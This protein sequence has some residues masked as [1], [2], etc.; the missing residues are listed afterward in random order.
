MRRPCGHVQSVQK[1]LAGSWTQESGNAVE[2]RRLAGTVR[3]DQRV[4][5]AVPHLEVDPVHRAQRAKI[6]RQIA[7]YK[8]GCHSSI[9]MRETIPA[10]PEGNTKTTT[11]KTTPNASCHTSKPV[12][13]AS[14]RKTNEIAPMIG[15]NNVPSPP[16][17][18]MIS[19]FPDST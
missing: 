4:H 9:Q 3:T 6:L 5:M 8:R 17:I 18:A 10:N 16:K 11:T 19:T 13:N 7:D 15:P 14:R 12:V 1:H 2:H